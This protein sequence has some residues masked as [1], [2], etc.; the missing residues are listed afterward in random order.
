MTAPPAA[1]HPVALALGGN[2]GD[3]LR[4]LETALDDLDHAPGLRLRARSSWWRSRAVGPPQPDYLNGCALLDT[5]LSPEA[6]LEVMQAIE[7]RHGRI[8]RERWGPRTLDLDLIFYADL[9]LDTERL[10]LPHPRFR[11]RAFVLMP[12]AELSPA[13]VDPVTGRTVAELAQAF[14]D[15][16]SVWPLEAER[17]RSP[18]PAP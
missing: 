14:E 16:D 18:S 13:W 1:S 15:Q 3:S 8:R 11:E 5:H 7:R 17:H 10:V 2:L 9:R 12:L 4:L 6:L